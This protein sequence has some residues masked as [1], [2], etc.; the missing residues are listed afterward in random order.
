M[1]LAMQPE[2]RRMHF[3]LRHRQFS[4]TDILERIELDLLESH[5]LPVHTHVAMRPAGAFRD[6]TGFA[7]EFFIAPWSAL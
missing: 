3:L 2:S 7:A 6:I 4:S 1:R 5:D